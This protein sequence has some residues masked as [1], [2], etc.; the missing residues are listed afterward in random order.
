[1][2][3]RALNHAIRNMTILDKRF[4]RNCCDMIKE[5]MEGYELDEILQIMSKKN[6][7]PFL[8]RRYVH[9]RVE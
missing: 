8:G 4:F 2:S 5:E 7:I 9:H 3:V 6:M 1:M